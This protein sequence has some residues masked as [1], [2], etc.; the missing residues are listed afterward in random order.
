M[1]KLSLT[2]ISSLTVL[3]FTWLLV[4]ACSQSSGTNPESSISTT[5]EQPGAVIGNVDTNIP[6]A[7]PIE[8]PQF[9]EIANAMVGRPAHTGQESSGVFRKWS[10]GGRGFYNPN[11][12]KL[13]ENFAE[14]YLTKA[15]L[16]TRTVYYPF[17]GP[18]VIYP[19]TFFPKT[20]TLILVGI[21][22][23]GELPT[24]EVAQ[25]SEYQESMN[26]MMEIYLAS[27]FYRTEDMRAE[28]ST[29]PNKATWAKMMAAIGL[30]DLRILTTETGTLNEEG[31]WLSDANTLEDQRNALSPRGVLFRCLRTIDGHSEF[32]A[33]YYFQQNLGESNRGSLYSLPKARPFRSFIDSFNGNYTSFLKAASYLSHYKEDFK[34]SN[35]LIFGG[36]KIIQAPSGVP[37]SEF[38][39]HRDTWKLSLFG[40]YR[41]PS[42][43]FEDHPQLDLRDAYASSMSGDSRGE[44]SDFVNYGGGLPFHYD[45]GTGTD[46]KG[47][48][49]MMFFAIK[50][51]SFPTSTELPNTK[52]AVP[53]AELP[54]AARGI[55]EK[56]KENPQPEAKKKRKPLLKWLFGK[57]DS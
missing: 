29:D 10:T 21:E 15:R 31:T 56:P 20:T 52:K 4:A 41:E 9:Q 32:V 45:Y 19:L 33:V 26:S 2:S 24:L 13:Y 25:G 51:S 40:E 1:K 36:N 17:G 30:L 6:R 28:A 23:I 46:G 27:S 49:S 38:V 44:Y 39:K 11:N 50:G 12:R 35:E 42:H 22:P 18:D 34:T 37:F 48:G 55:P 14:A 7:I 8:D 5:A 57:G 16:E 47:K 54:S 3:S 43:L 53:R